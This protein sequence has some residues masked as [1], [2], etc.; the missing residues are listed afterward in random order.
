M[1]DDDADDGGP[2][3]PIRATVVDPAVFGAVDA[4][5]HDG[6]LRE[7]VQGRRPGVSPVIFSHPVL[8]DFAVAVTCLRGEDHL[9]LS[10]R[11]AIDPD[12]AITVR[13]SLDMHF[14]DLWTDDTTREP[15]W[16]LAVTL[17]SA[18]P[19]PSDRGRRG[20]LRRTP[21]NTPLTTTLRTLE[22]AGDII[23]QQ[24]VRRP[25]CASRTSP[26]ALEAAEVSRLDRQASAPALA[27][28]AATLAAGA[29]ATGDIGTGR[30]RKS[31]AVA[32]GPVLP[33][34]TGCHRC[35]DAQPR[36]RRR[37]ALRSS[38]PSEPAREELAMRIAEALAGAAV[39][40]LAMSAR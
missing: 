26:A 3:S 20:R 33:S 39:V 21:A 10:R 1:R 24:R 18:E 12:L 25:G 19:R 22:R 16:D 29:A 17:S 32:P 15:F 34:R 37:D 35:R 36:D 30:P 27:E 13:P 11:L 31:P 4:L 8:Y 6:V 5:L 38:D 2:A 14:A 40:T 28:L 23:R 9:Y 7:D